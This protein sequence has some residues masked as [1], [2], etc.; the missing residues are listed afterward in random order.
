[1]SPAQLY[2]SLPNIM[3]KDYNAENQDIKMVTDDARNDFKFAL[4]AS[5]LRIRSTSN[6][7]DFGDFPV[8]EAMIK[9]KSDVSILNPE[10]VEMVI[11]WMI[12][13]QYERIRLENAPFNNVNEGIPLTKELT[14]GYNDFADPSS[15]HRA[16]KLQT[17]LLDIVN[18]A[19]GMKVIGMP[20][21][22]TEK[23][24]QDILSGEQNTFLRTI[25]GF[26]KIGLF[27]IGQRTIVE[28][29]AGESFVI[30]YEGFKNSDSYRNI[31]EVI[32]MFGPRISEQKGGE[33][34]NKIKIGTNNYYTDMAVIRNFFSGKAIHKRHL[35]KIKPLK[36]YEGLT[37]SLAEELVK[38]ETL[39]VSKWVGSFKDENFEDTFEENDVIV[40]G[41]NS[42]GLHGRGGAGF[43]M[44]KQRSLKQIEAIEDGVEGNYAVKGETGLMSGAKGTG[45]GLIT[46]AGKPKGRYGGQTMTRA[47]IIAQI[48]QLYNVAEENSDNNFKVIYELKANEKSL[49]G[50][51]GQ[52][53]AD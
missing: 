7:F 24:E 10:F 1:M 9:D 28:S 46:V 39:A 20:E 49:N 13:P 23:E 15:D 5:L 32:E 14:I 22:V 42:L 29:K 3:L 43:A 11:R 40:F 36:A 12:Q 44:G 26:Q 51:T 17:D 35:Y 16:I 34:T 31:N 45:Y 27:Q 48:K 25:A 41:A 21:F 47:E 18:I 4:L 50:Y 6:T 30:T 19:K 53:I 8:I 2:S 37:G 52:E 33:F 38:R